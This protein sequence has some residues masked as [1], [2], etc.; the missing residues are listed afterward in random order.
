MPH[1]GDTRQKREDQS[2]GAVLPITEGG[3]IRERRE[4]VGGNHHHLQDGLL[5]LRSLSGETEGRN[6]LKS[7]KRRGARKSTSRDF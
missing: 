5:H 3:D 2:L 7:E 6:Y 1:V 4:R